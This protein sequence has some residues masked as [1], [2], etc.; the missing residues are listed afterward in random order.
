MNDF[1]SYVSRHYKGLDTLSGDIAG[2]LSHP[3]I[4]FF[5]VCMFYNA[6][7]TIVMA[8][9]PEQLQNALKPNFI[10]YPAIHTNY[11]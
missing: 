1:E 8:E 5:Y 3:D 4:E 9:T 10:E 7:D 11:S 2:H 6:D